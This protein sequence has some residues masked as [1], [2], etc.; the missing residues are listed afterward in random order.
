[1]MS[2]E[3]FTILTLWDAASDIIRRTEPLADIIRDVIH[4]LEDILELLPAQN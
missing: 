2:N 1:M 3:D 4:D